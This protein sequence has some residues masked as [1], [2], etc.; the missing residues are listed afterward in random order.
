VESPFTCPKSSL[1]NRVSDS[2]PGN[3]DHRSRRERVKRLCDQALYRSVFAG[4]QHVCVG[5]PTREIISITG[6]LAAIR[7]RFGILP[8]ALIL[9]LRACDRALEPVPAQLGAH[10]CQQSSLSHGLVTNPAP[11]FHCSTARSMTPRC[12]PHQSAHSWI[13]IAVTFLSEVVFRACMRSIITARNLFFE[14]AKDSSRR[15]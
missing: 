3:S 14:T 4:D 12:H 15:P 2:P 8:R 1:S 6:R 5:R 9:R 11:P 13:L 7:I 10:N